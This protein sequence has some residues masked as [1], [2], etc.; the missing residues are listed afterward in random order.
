M[1]VASCSWWVSEH[2][3]TDQDDRRPWTGAS[4]GGTVAAMLLDALIALQRSDVSDA[5]MYFR[6]KETLPQIMRTTCFQPTS[7]PI[8]LGGFALSNG[9]INTPDMVKEQFG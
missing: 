4:Y 7:L 5:I 2:L 9:V 3:D 1:S 8:N 6:E